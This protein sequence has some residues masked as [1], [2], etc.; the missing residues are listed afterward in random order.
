MTHSTSEILMGLRS[1]TEH[2]AHAHIS[3]ML[4]ASSD[5]MPQYVEPAP[6]SL[7]TPTRQS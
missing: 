2:E 6:Y 3:A 1:T 4:A 7:N 5:P